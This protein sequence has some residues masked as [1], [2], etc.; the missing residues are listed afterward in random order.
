M[1]LSRFLFFAVVIVSAFVLSGCWDYLDIENRAYVYGIAV[2]RNPDGDGFLA[3]VEIAHPQ[4]QPQSGSPGGQLPEPPKILKSRAGKTLGDALYHIGDGHLSRI[5]LWQEVK[6][7]FISDDVAREGIGPVIDL[8]FRSTVLNLRSYMY[9]VEGSAAEPLSWLPDFQPLVSR[10]V[11]E[12]ERQFAKNPLYAKPKS[13]IMTTARLIEAGVVLLPRVVIENGE[14]RLKGSAVIRDG[15]WVGWLDEPTSIGTNW[16][17]GDLDRVMA[18][19]GCPIDDD[20]E[21]TVELNAA[22]HQLDLAIDG[23]RIEARYRIVA[24]MRML[25]MSGCHLNPN[26]LEDRQLLERVAAEWIRRHLE[27]AITRAQHE[28]GVDFLGINV[29]FSRRFPHLWRQ[30]E[31]DDVFPKIDIRVE[32][33]VSLVHPGVLQIGPIIR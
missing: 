13:V 11:R 5:P 32:P 4:G 22:R 7:I 6:A 16:L 25:D 15:V 3:T 8:F 24:N 28:L 31:W 17:I 30:I 29:A 19:V 20:E 14:V 1:R 9:I 23:D 27:L 33:T 2:D 18:Q 12:M 10:Y 26:D 21:I